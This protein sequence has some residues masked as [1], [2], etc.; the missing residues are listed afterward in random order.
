MIGSGSLRLE[1]RSLVFGGQGTVSP[2]W[3]LQS[4][5]TVPGMWTQLP[6]GWRGVGSAGSCCARS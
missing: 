4:V 1:D 3:L 6:A 5:Y 2:S